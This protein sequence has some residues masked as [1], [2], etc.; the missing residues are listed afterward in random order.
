[1]D[2]FPSAFKRFEESRYAKDSYKSIQDLQT[3]FGVFQK[4]YPTYKQRKCLDNYDYLVEE[5]PEPVKEEYTFKRKEL[6][7][8]IERYEIK[9]GFKTRYRDNKT[10]RF[11]KRPF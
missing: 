4:Y 7:Y 6:T 2:K 5:K 3:R 8:R 11:I 9:T 10:G 1:M